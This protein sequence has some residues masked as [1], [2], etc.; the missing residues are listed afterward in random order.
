MLN[1]T[2]LHLGIAHESQFQGLGISIATNGTGSI[3]QFVSKATGLKLPSGLLAISPL[4]GVAYRLIDLHSS[5]E[6]CTVNSLVRCRWPARPHKTPSRADAIRRHVPAFGAP[7][8]P[9]SRQW[10]GID[11]DVVRSRRA[12]SSRRRRRV[13]TRPGRRAV[14]GSE[15]SRPEATAAAW[16][17]RN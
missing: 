13:R 7:R 17:Y 6:G 12:G 9:C 16:R 2:R 10:P 3:R 11:D 4:G 15:R 5:S 14:Q 8:A 1:L